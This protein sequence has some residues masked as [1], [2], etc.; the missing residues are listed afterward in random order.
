MRGCPLAQL[1]SAAVRPELY[2]D[3][4][5]VVDDPEEAFLAC[6]RVADLARRDD[7]VDVP[8]GESPE[9][10]HD[11]AE[12]VL[13]FV[14]ADLLV[15]VRVE[16]PQH[17]GQAAVRAL[18]EAGKLR[19]DGG[20]RL[21]GR[22]GARD[23]RPFEQRAGRDAEDPRGAGERVAV[24]LHRAVDDG[25]RLLR[26]AADHQARGE[27]ARMAAEQIDARGLLPEAANDGLRSLRRIG[28][29]TL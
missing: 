28:R 8:A 6:R 29:H 27:D 21:E 10:P 16:Q 17:D 24:E 15:V 26:G 1:K 25:D 3:V 11:A 7:G 2:H 4:R 18:Q 5:G 20:L 23:V 9:R 22:E 19:R 14:R 13:A 12:A